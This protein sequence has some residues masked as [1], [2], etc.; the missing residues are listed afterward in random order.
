ML[1]K[2]YANMVMAE[3]VIPGCQTGNHTR[4]VENS[5]TNGAKCGQSD[6]KK[7][8]AMD[9]QETVVPSLPQDRDDKLIQHSKLGRHYT[10]SAPIEK[11]NIFY[12]GCEGRTLSNVI[13][14]YKC[15]QVWLPCM[16]RHKLHQDFLLLV[17]LL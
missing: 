5:A 15:C 2:D 17:L 12:I 6:N 3:L 1:K 16:L 9:D 11:Y 7:D 4:A 13:I 10:L 8:E 14:S